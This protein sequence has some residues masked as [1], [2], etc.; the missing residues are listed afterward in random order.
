[1][2]N[3]GDEISKLQSLWKALYERVK[4]AQFR[5]ENSIEDYFR[6]RTYKE[7]YLDMGK[8]FPIK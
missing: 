8:I 1:M 5:A 7:L 2:S 6:K 4:I 3:Y